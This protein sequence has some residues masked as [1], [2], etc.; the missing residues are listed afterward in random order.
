MLHTPISS[1][2][3]YYFWTLVRSKKDCLYK[4]LKL[5]D[6]SEI[7]SELLASDCGETDERGQRRPSKDTSESSK[8]CLKVSCSYKISLRP[9]KQKTPLWKID[10]QVSKVEY[11]SV[12]LVL[13]W[14]SSRGGGSSGPGGLL[15]GRH[16]VSIFWWAF[17][18]SFSA[19]EGVILLVMDFHKSSILP[20]KTL[21]V[22]WNLKCKLIL[23]LTVV[24]MFPLKN[25]LFF[26]FYFY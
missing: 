21:K 5:F 12:W 20:W 25:T 13:I 26:P 4:A 8:K 9:V 1:L 22:T 7:W 16:F 23:F 11:H 17:N 15:P 14:S 6:G 19:V 10:F 2:R 24:L 3:F 18:L